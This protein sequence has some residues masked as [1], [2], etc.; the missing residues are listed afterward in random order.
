MKT[1]H[2]GCALVLLA[3]TLSCNWVKERSKDTIKGTGEVVGK[4]GSEFASGVAKGVGQTFRSK[5]A[6]SDSLVQAGLTIGEITIGSADS[7]ND[8]NLSV[9]LIFNKAIDRVVTAKVFTEDG[10]EYGRVTQRIKGAMGTAGFVDFVFDKRTDISLKSK[11]TL[12]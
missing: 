5:I 7:M 10:L 11:I 8:N 9:Y 1:I 12:E 3:I 6:V 4:A 2:S